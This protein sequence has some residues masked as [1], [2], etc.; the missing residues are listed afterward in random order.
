MLPLPLAGTTPQPRQDNDEQPATAGTGAWR[1][2]RTGDRT[3]V[4]HRPSAGSPPRRYWLTYRTAT[5]ATGREGPEPSP[6]G[7]AA[8]E[9]EAP[10]PDLPPEEGPT[11]A[12]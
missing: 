3:W 7:S 5:D 9:F 1:P 2:P 6:T 10:A 12:P 8:R 4:S 11:P